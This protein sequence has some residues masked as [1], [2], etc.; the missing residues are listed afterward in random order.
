MNRILPMLILAIVS[1]ALFPGRTIS[2]QNQL[3]RRHSIRQSDRVATLALSQ[4]PE[5]GRE[6]PPIG[7]P[8]RTLFAASQSDAQALTEARKLL[9]KVAENYKDMKSYQFEATLL[10][11]T[12]NE[13]LQFKSESRSEEAFVIAAIKPDRS[14]C[15]SKG[16]NLNLLSVSDG[17]TNWFY[18]PMFKQYIKRPIE[19]SKKKSGINPLEVDSGLNFFGFD[20]VGSFAALSTYRLSEYERM[21]EEVKEAKLLREDAITVGNRKIECYIIEVESVI[22]GLEESKRKT[23]WI[24]K[25]RHIVMRSVVQSKA[26]NPF[27]GAVDTTVTTNFTLAKIDEPVSEGL[28]A[29]IPPAEA[30]EVEKFEFP[31]LSGR[32]KNEMTG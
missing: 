22:S 23:F 32:K 27:G 2:G 17:K 15:E 20:M 4:A 5:V 30:K 10:T 11:E 16:P 7:N 8:L 3:E 12:K 9:K 21:A 1:S 29:F 18:L 13:A 14:M 26:K 28:F 19:A 25:A 6:I 24:D 31:D